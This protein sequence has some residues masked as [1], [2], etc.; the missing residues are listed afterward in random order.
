MRT[1]IALE[2]PAKLRAEVAEIS[3]TLAQRCRGHFMPYENLHVTL[4]FLGEISETEAGEAIAAL[5]EVCS[6][7]API[8]LMPEGLGK[9]GRASDATLWLGFRKSDELMAAATQVR[10]R[11]SAHGLSFDEKPFLPHVTL[12]RRVSL[13]RDALSTLPFPHEAQASHITL[14]KST[15]SSK[16]ATYMPLYTVELR[17]N[18]ESR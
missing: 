16:G 2:L 4:A 12:A 9:F 5:N 17:K 3:R 14:F 1:F 18:E 6:D 11:L 15:L 8:P 10:E 13:P 7:L